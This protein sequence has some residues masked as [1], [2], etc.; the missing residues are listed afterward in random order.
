M[1]TRRP[2]SHTPPRLGAPVVQRSVRSIRTRKESVQEFLKLGHET[3]SV[4]SQWS[5]VGPRYRGPR[6][7]LNYHGLSRKVF[8]TVKAGVIVSEKGLSDE[9]PPAGRGRCP[10]DR[11]VPG[12]GSGRV[13]R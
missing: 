2:A 6:F 12:D 8:A 13:A 11:G 5:L 1:A 10:L 4:R 3:A 7:L 9:C